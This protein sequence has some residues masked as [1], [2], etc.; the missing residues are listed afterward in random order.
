MTSY[1]EL[2]TMIRAALLADPGVE[3]AET[4]IAGGVVVTLKTGEAFQLT[5][6]CITGRRS[7][8]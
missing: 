1:R 8:S 7:T 6:L 4:T 3:G 2:A 5:P